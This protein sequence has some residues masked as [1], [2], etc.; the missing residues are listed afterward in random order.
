MSE[1]LS[2]RIIFNINWILVESVSKVLLTGLTS[3]V[4]ARYLGAD[5]LGAISI[6]LSI[7][8]VF[9]VI[10]ALGLERV[11]LRELEDPNCNQEKLVGGVILLRSL[12]AFVA[13]LLVNISAVIFYTDNSQLQF[14]ILLLSFA[15]FMAVGNS[16]EVLYRRQLRS[17]TVTVIRVLGLIASAISK[18]AIVLLGLEVIWFTAPLL[19]ETAVVSSSFIYLRFNDSQLNLG[20]LRVEGSEARRIFRIAWPLLLSGIA[21][22]LYFQAD[23]ILIFEYLSEASLGR[24]T[25]L[26]QLVSMVFLAMNAINLSVTPVL[27]KMYFKNLAD[28]WRHFREIAAIKC[29]LSVICALGLVLLGNTVIPFLV[30]DSFV[31]DPL[32]LVTFA[33]YIFLV[34]LTSLNAEYCVLAGVLKPLFYIRMITLA[35]NILLNLYLIPRWGLLGAAFATLASD[36]VF[37]IVLPLCFPRMRVVVLNNLVS[38]KYLFYRDVYSKYVM[39]LIG[40]LPG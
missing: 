2:A 40:L 11:I 38:L 32:T 35:F 10:S 30:G 14:M 13:F 17:K 5:G 33:V 19:I 15:Y 25:L 8:S 18:I 36:F 16:L 9:A 29:F 21:G 22:T 12:G 1:S 39:K 34:S 28:Y 3:I 20:R 37:K 26:V 27:N 7:H 4:V 23:K 6:A 31:Y 24:Y